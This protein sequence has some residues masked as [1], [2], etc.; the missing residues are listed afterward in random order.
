MELIIGGRAQGK[1][2]Y[3]QSLNSEAAG[4]K[5]IDNLQDIIYSLLKEGKDAEAETDA[6]LVEAETENENLIVICD[7]V[8]CGIVPI[9]KFER[10][11]R[12]IVGKICIK[13]AKR[14]GRVHRV[15][16]GIGTVIK[17]A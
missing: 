16:C 1:L 17:D 7:E 12:E 6:L 11:Y 9:D 14:A 10:A 3:A 5:I 8:G 4:V 15:I 13:L 2:E